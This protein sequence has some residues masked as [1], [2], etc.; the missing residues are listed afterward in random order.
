[1]TKTVTAEELRAMLL[2]GEELALLDVREEGAFSESHLLFASS[3]PLSRLEFGIDALVPRRGTRTVLCDDGSGLAERAAGKLSGFGYTDVAVLDGGT[4]AWERAGNVLFSGIYVPSKAFGEYVEETC[5]TPNITAPELKARLDAGDDVV[6]LDSRP[7]DEFRRMNIPTAIDVPGAELAY[8]VH[9]IAPSPDTTVVV[10]CAGRTRSIIGAQSLIKSGV[11]NEVMALRNGTMGWELAGFELERGNE[12][13]PPAVTAE[14]LARAREGA[15][16][17]AAS[18]GIETIDRARLESWRAEAGRRS[19]F[20]L[21]V[22]GVEEYEAG[23]LAGSRPIPGGQLVQTTDAVIGTRNARA[24]LIDDTG[25]R[26]TMTAAWLVEMGWPEVAVYR[27]DPS[28]DE[29][30]TGPWEPAVLGLDRAEARS[31]GVDTLAAGLSD[32]TMAAVDLAGSRAYLAGHVPGAGFALRSRLDGALDGLPAAETVV[33]ISSDGLLARLA[34]AERGGD[35]AYLEGGTEAWIGAGMPLAEGE[36]LMLDS[37]DD[38]WLRP[39]DR[40]GDV[41]QAMNAYLEWELQLVQ[42]VEADGT[43]RF[44]RFDG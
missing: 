15:A 19:L 20:L 11:P 33:L 43:A 30:E 4:G 10:N 35:F 31:V 27:L 39:Y 3:L 38:V 21:D 44:R 29:V 2:D 23:H 36:E 12:R 5:H 34:A 41:A 17:V 37:T 1:M 16:R 22:R 32:G 7:M 6:V 9:D 14:G 8:R 18:R 13:P 24:V 40:G 28:V 26:A 25:V 42:Q